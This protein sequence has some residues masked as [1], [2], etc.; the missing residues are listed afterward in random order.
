MNN[1][2]SMVIY[3]PNLTDQEAVA[4]NDKLIDLIKSLKGEI[5]KTDN[6]G[7]RSL[8]YE[9]NKKREGHYVINYFK[10]PPVSISEIEKFYRLSE[11]IMRN[12][13]LTLEE[14]S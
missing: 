5:V 8:A 1:Y 3:T 11:T 4:E 2:E 10:L 6:W 7:K 12:N 14:G 9:I 13:I